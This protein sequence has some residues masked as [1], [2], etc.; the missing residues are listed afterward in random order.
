MFKIYLNKFRFLCECPVCAAEEAEEKAV[1]MDEKK[2]ENEK[3]DEKK[4]ETENKDNDA[5][6]AEIET[7]GKKRDL[8][9]DGGKNES[10]AKED[11]ATTIEDL[12]AA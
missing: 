6:A 4:L 8:E 10:T 2:V 12:Q 9:E 1:T 5:A 3:K 7:G 11:A